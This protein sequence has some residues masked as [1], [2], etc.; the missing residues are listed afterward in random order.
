MAQTDYFLKLDGVEAEST[1]DKHKGE[2]EVLSFSWGVSNAG[3]A[4]RGGGQGGGKSAA[5]D[6]SFVKQLD[7][8]S[9][10][11]YIACATGQHFKNAVL[12]CRK[13][14][15]GQQEYLKFTLED[16]FISSHVTSGSGGGD[17]VPT[18]SVTLNF[19]KME[20]SYKEQKVDGS[21]GGEVKQKYDFAANKKL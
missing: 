20:H 13:A 21:L 2:I 5:T 17:I 12:T 11:L 8:S 3:T 10:T 1:D 18:E 15:G 7:K 6:L 9:P 19:A 14:G 4:G 16:V